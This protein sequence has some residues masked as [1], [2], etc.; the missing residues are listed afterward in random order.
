VS[1]PG[2]RPAQAQV[3]RILAERDGDLVELDLLPKRGCGVPW[4]RFGPQAACS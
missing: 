3:G 4:P 1:E 2:S